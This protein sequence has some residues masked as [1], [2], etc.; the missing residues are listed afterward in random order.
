[1]S[2]I[3]YCAPL[4]VSFGLAI[5]SSISFVYSTGYLNGE[6][7]DSAIQK[8]GLCYVGWRILGFLPF[9]LLTAL[10]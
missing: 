1:V 3:I 8:I 4:V 6:V 9:C 5:F 10:I 2:A 7:P